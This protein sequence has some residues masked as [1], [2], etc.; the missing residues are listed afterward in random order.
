MKK[1]QLILIACCV[2]SLSAMLAASDHLDAP[3]VNEDGRLDVND[4]YVFQS[5]ANIHRSVLIM[6]VNPAAGVLSP[7]TFNPAG[8]YEFNIDNSGDAVPD[9]TFA[10]RFGEPDKKGQQR[11]RLRRNGALVARGKTGQNVRIRSAGRGMVRC[12]LFDDPFFFDLNG[13]NDGFQFT[14]EDFF[15]GLNVSGIVIEIPTALLTNSAKGSANVSLCCR[16]TID[17]NQFDR[18][19]R[20]AINTVLIPSGLKDAFNAGMPVND[21]ADFSDVV[22]A[23]IE[24]LNGGDTET[25]QEL[26]A[27]LLP[28]VLTVDLSSSDGFL[29][30]RLLADDV[31]DAE[32]SLLS[33]GAVTG[34]MV[35]AN[36]VPFKASFPYLAAAHE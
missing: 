24:G 14:G 10:L 16:T 20:P 3:L 5:P 34:D 13:F 29:N 23:S 19:G 18:V 2:A 12:G 15:A 27:I 32:L 35:D 7:T 1:L 17:G 31:I 6:T 11:F 22:Q 30:G 21:F 28:D 4:S 8:V 9:I 25:A 33:N 26:T 36:D